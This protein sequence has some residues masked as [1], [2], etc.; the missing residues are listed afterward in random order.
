MCELMVKAN[1]YHWMDDL[2]QG[3]LNKLHISQLESYAKR[4]RAGH[5]I[6]IRADGWSF[7]GMWSKK[8]G[9]PYCVIIKIPGLD[10]FSVSHYRSRLFDAE[11]AQG[12][13]KMLSVRRYRVNP[14]LIQN[15]VNDSQD[16]VTIATQVGFEA[17]LTDNAT[18]AQP[19]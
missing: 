13:R 5:V 16:N 9:L 11:D 8:T 15:M 18:V 2:N 4:Y 7:A 6:T 10:M 12:K 17:L 1:D 3:Q 19:D 14:T